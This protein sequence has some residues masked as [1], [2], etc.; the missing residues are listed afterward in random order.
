MSTLATKAQYDKL[1]ETLNKYVDQYYKDNESAIGDSEFDSMYLEIEEIENENPEWI[2]IDSPTQ[3]VMGGAD[4]SFEKVKHAVSMLSLGKS[5]NIIDLHKF[6]NYLRSLDIF[7]VSIEGKLDGLAC[8]LVYSYGRLKQGATRGDGTIGEDITQ[9]VLM[10]PAIPKVINNNDEYFEVRGEIFLPKSG[11]SEIN[12]A[13]ALANARGYKNVRNAASGILRSKTPEA[14]QA[15]YLKFGAYMLVDADQKGFETHNEAMDYLKTLEFTIVNQL[16]NKMCLYEVNGD[17]KSFEE[18]LAS[19]EYYCNELAENRPN[20]DFDIDG[21]VFKAN[22]FVDQK[23]L[24][25][26]TNCPNWATAYKFPAMTAVTILEGVDWL[27]GSKGNITPVARVKTVNL[28]GV[29]ISNVTLHNI[30][31][32]NR[33]GAKIGDHVTISRQGDVIPK[34]INVLVDL[35]VGTETDII[36]PKH[37]PTCGGEVTE[38]GIFIRCDNGGCSGR[39]AGRIENLVTKLE[40]KDLGVGIIEKMVE[41]KLVTDPADIFSL[42]IEDI[43][44]LDRTGTKTATKIVKNIEKAKSAPLAKLIAGLTIPGVGDN[45][46]K[47][48]SK[49][50]GTLTAFSMA[51]FDELVEIQDMGPTGAQKIIDWLAEPLNIISLSKMA[52][53]GIGST[54]EAA[55]SGDKLQ[56]KTFAFTGALSVGRKEIVK[57]IEDNGGIE[58]SI[59]KGLEYLILG[60][61]GKEAKAAKA[62]GF[63]A[64]IINESEFMEMLK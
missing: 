24:G 9:T 50:Y 7:N 61:G 35:R 42:T 13:L 48:L 63:G 41:A 43:A 49:R 19:I 14:G 31:E 32:I 38:N 54:P 1:V 21:I 60:D 45:S 17:A 46:G 29:D 53:T 26:K 25:L 23:R 15:F 36:V 10:I 27:L 55:P 58:S 20:L 5:M 28:C 12:M 3:K 16:D 18:V 2:R 52:L 11:L 22:K 62:E 37:C 59:K 47:N 39:L 40:I 56:G 6:M 44:A 51:K 64:K 57:L 8:K 33:L 34:I 30:E 4:N